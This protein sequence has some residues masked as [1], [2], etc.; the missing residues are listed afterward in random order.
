M[1]KADL[2]AQWMEAFGIA[3]PAKASREFL[4]HSLAYRLQERALGGLTPA[5]RQRLK[6]LANASGSA[7][8]FARSVKPTLKPGT[9]LIRAWKGSLHEVEVLGDGFVWQGQAY[10]N[11]SRI[12]RAITGTRWSGPLFFGLKERNRPPAHSTPVEKAP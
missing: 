9:R 7:A 10:P 2:K 5:V 1:T 8:G 6:K 4:A 11:L 3:P 12:A